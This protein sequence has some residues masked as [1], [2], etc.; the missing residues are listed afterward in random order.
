[1]A[2]LNDA[3]LGA[4]KRITE[5]LGYVR[6]SLVD[7]TGVSVAEK[8]AKYKTEFVDPVSA[9]LTYICQE[10][11]QEEWLVKKIDSTSGTQITYATI[12]NNPTITT[13]A[14]AKAGRASLVYGLPSEAL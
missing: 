11:P 3:I 10:S 2:Y 14:L 4:Y 9:T 13:Y 1:M 7:D 5:V 6:V 12:K 8:T